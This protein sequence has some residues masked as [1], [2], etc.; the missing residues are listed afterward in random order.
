MGLYKFPKRFQSNGINSYLTRRRWNPDSGPTAVCRWRRVRKISASFLMRWI[1][2]VDG[3][4]E[5]RL[6]FLATY[7]AR[8]I[9]YLFCHS[10]G[11]LGFGGWRSDIAPCC[12]HIHTRSRRNTES[13]RTRLLPA[14]ITPHNS[15]SRVAR[16]IPRQIFRAICPFAANDSKRTIWSEQ[17]EASD[18]ERASLITPPLRKARTV[19]RARR[20]GGTSNWR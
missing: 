8:R 13:C 11:R 12:T 3:E 20:F 2:R 16:T 7:D 6:L 5:F 14:N 18:S 19:I 10:D 9:T 15:I 17:H 1:F 4:S